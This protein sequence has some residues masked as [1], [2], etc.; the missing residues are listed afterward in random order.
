MTVPSE[1]N[2]NGTGWTVLRIIQFLI[3]TVMWGILAYFVDTYNKAGL[4]TPDGVMLLFIVGILASIWTLSTL[5]LY[6]RANIVPLWVVFW[7]VVAMA[8]FI[9]GVVMIGNVTE[10]NCVAYYSSWQQTT[11]YRTEWSANGDPSDP[12]TKIILG[13][14]ARETMYDETGPMVYNKPCSLLKA[15]FGLAIAAIVLFFFTALLGIGVYRDVKERGNRRIIKEE[16]IEEGGYPGGS[17]TVIE[18]QKVY[19]RPST[20]PSVYL[21]PT[22]GAPPGSVYDDPSASAVGYE[23]ERRR[24]RSETGRSK[25]SHR[26]R[27]HSRTYVDDGYGGSEYR[28]SEYRS[29]RRSSS[30]RRMDREGPRS[31]VGYVRGV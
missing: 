15:A 19:E 24:S 3:I 13:D 2:N 4:K 1:N 6:M 27:R 30:G 29:S 23:R 10:S 18:E 25:R 28:G 14:T 7:D 31:S 16:I 20:P 21:G 5:I 17:R 9:A 8:L 22:A 11:W 12:A 26:S